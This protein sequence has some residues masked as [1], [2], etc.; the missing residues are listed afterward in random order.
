MIAFGWIGLCLGR[1]ARRGGRK[2]N[3]AVRTEGN[4]V[5]GGGG[6]GGV[7]LQVGSSKLS[8]SALTGCDYDAS[9]VCLGV[10]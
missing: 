8:M 2:D 1:L 6:E 4:I 10:L 5:F 3:A 7:R 9:N